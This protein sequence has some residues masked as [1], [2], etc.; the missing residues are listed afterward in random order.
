MDGEGGR[1]EMTLVI[2]VAALERVSDPETVVDD[3]RQWSTRV[4]VVGDA[5]PDEIT[6]ALE[7]ADIDPDFVSGKKGVTGSLAAVRQR[8]PTDRY[9]VVGTDDAVR[10]TAQALGWEYLSLE[11]A[12]A[13]AE[14]E[15]ETSSE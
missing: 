4:G 12:A 9:V 3:A 14:W 11:E 8:F 10:T 15:L 1:G 5:A 6:T 13:K 2:T 7:R